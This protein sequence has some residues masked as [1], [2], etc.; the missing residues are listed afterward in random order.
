[1]SV[2]VAK[3]VAIELSRLQLEDEELENAKDR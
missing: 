1:M 2:C 3:A